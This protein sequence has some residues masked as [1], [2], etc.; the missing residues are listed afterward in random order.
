M[1][2][3]QLQIVIDFFPKDKQKSLLMLAAKRSLCNPKYFRNMCD[4]V[5]EAGNFRKTVTAVEHCPVGMLPVQF[6]V[7]KL[8]LKLPSHVDED[9]QIHDT[10][11]KR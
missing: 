10:H 7:Q 3:N 4:D 11:L 2:Y 8:N 1:K 9:D 6:G 5:V